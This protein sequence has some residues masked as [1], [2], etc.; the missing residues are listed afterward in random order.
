MENPDIEDSDTSYF[1]IG[2]ALDCLL[3]SPERWELDFNVVDANRPYG[4]MGKFID[5]LPR[6]LTAF[7][8]NELYQE[9]YDKSGYKMSI[10]RV[11][12]KF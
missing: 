2:S 9:A 10:D 6:N 4:L 11:I 7:S 8:E 1:R 12:K 3:T 5:N